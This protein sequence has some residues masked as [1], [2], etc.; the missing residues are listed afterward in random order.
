M[1]TKTGKRGMRNLLLKTDAMRGRA[2]TPSDRVAGF[3]LL[4]LSGLIDFREPIIHN[5]EKP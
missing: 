3:L 1:F 2:S 4:F 5:G